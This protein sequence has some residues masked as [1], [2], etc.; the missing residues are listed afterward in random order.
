MLRSSTSWWL[1]LIAA[2]AGCIIPF[3][4]FLSLASGYSTK[5][6]GFWT[7][8]NSV[9]FRI[10]SN[11]SGMVAYGVTVIFSMVVLV[12]GPQFPRRVASVLAIYCVAI[13]IFIIIG[14]YF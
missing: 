11:V 2:I 5:F 1:I 9:E 8:P 12:R 10:A 3:T 4:L 14:K 6:L 7:P 13:C